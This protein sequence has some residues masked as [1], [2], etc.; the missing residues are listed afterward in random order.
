MYSEVGHTQIE[1]TAAYRIPTF[2][3]GG[4][5]IWTGSALLPTPLFL[6][7]LRLVPVTRRRPKMSEKNIESHDEKDVVVRR[8]SRISVDA[9]EVLANN[10]LLNDAYDGENR[11]HAMGLWAA[12]KSHPKACFW[13]FIMCF[14]IVSISPLI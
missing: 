5:D 1:P 8:G 12:A 4:N 3:D 14:T 6:H 2:V 11:E 9:S 10:A 7:L 13:A